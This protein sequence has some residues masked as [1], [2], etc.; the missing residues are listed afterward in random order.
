MHRTKNDLPETTRVAMI[1][2]LNDRLADAIDLFNQVKHAHWNVKGPNFIAIH[3]LFDQVA[4]HVEEASDELA[5]RAVQLGGVADGLTASIAK[6]T[7]IKSIGTD[8]PD[9]RSY[10]DAVSTSLAEY[11]AKIRQAI[12]TADKAGDKNTADLFTELSRNADKDLWFV[13]AHLYSDR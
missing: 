4:E 9:G 12:D 6:R 11:G 8:L 7:S 3:E 10:V 13:E 1:K 2:L 5:E